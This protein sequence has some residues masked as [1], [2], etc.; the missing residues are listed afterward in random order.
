MDIG[1]QI[2]FLAGM[3]PVGDVHVVDFHQH[4]GRKAKALGDAVEGVAGFDAVGLGRGNLDHLAQV[5]FVG[6]LQFIEL[7]QLVLRRRQPLGDHIDRI[8]LPDLDRM[9][10]DRGRRDL[11][12]DAELVFGL[13][14]LGRPHTHDWARRSWRRRSGRGGRD[15]RGHGRRDW[16]GRAGWRRGGRGHFR[17]RTIDRRCG[18]AWRTGRGRITI[19]VQRARSWRRRG[20]GAGGLIGDRL[21]PAGGLR[22]GVRSRDQGRGQ[23]RIGQPIEY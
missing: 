23:S 9:A 6:L 2:D 10:L 14:R 20:R 3:Q 22:L 11:A 21:G 1:R 4:L 5:Q 15:R 17:G 18:V 19:I 7:D 8:A 12:L 16:R 13:G